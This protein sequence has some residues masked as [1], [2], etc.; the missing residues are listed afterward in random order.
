MRFRIPKVKSYK[1]YV[2][3]V[4]VSTRKKRADQVGE[5]KEAR[6]GVEDNKK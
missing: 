5:G 6:R 4:P 2:S 3:R 1:N